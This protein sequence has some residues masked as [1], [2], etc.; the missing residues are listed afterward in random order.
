M[1]EDGEEKL[2]ATVQHIV[3]SNYD[4]CL[5]LDKLYTTHA[6]AAVAATVGGAG[7]HSMPASLP[8]PPPPA[9]SANADAFLEAVNDLIGTVHE[10]DVAGTNRGLLDLT[11]EL[12]SRCM[13]RLEDEFWALIERP[14]DATPQVPGGFEYDESEEEEYGANDGFGNE[15]IPVAR[16]VSDFDVVIDALPPGSISDVHQ[17]ARRMVDTGFGRECAEA[18]AV[19]RLSIRPCTIDEVHSL[20]WEELEFDIARWIPA[21][22]MR[23]I[24]FGDAVA[25]AGR[26]PELL[27]RVIDKYEAVRDLLSDL[28][29]VFSDP[30]S[31]ALRAELENLIRRDLARV[32]TPGGGIHPITRYMVNYLHAACGSRQTLEEVMEGDLGAVGAAAIVADPD[33]PLETKSKIYRDPPLASI[34]L[35]NNA[36]YIIHKVNDS[37][38]GILLGDEWMKQMMSRVRRWS[39]EYQCGAWAKVMSMLQTGGPGVGSITANAMLQKMKMFN[40]YLEE[41]C[42]VQSDWVIADEQLRADVKST[43]VDNVMPAYRGL[44]GRLRSSPEAARDLFIKYTPE[45]VQAS[46]QHLFEGVAK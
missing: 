31:A 37:E 39:M 19:A 35:M 24:S 15:P 21:F 26:A 18:Y 1:A 40:G 16:P 29:P 34:F 3:F 6:A 38:L 9:D 7:E 42:A 36:K 28:D 33:P 12:L 30:Y 17:I 27:F 25:A 44:I 14:D 43:I 32:A 22:K 45:D 8:M 5:S 46:I 23:F 11:D 2:L 41:I 4:N 13:A 20:P 10:L